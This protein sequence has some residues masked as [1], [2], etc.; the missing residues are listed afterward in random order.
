MA[1]PVSPICTAFIA[2]QTSRT[3]ERGR[4]AWLACMVLTSIAGCGGGETKPGG[5]TLSAQIEAAKANPNPQARA[6][7][8]VLL[9]DKQFQAQDTGGARETFRLA[10]QAIGQIKEPSGKAMELAVLAQGYARANDPSAAKNMAQEGKQVA[11]GISE[12]FLKVAAYASLAK[13][14]GVAKSPADAVDLLRDAENV[15]AGFNASNALEQQQQVES[16][17]SIA[18]VYHAVDRPANA[19]ALF[20]RIDQLCENID[21]DRAR[22]D[23][24]STLAAA[25]AKLG[26]P[27]AAA[28]F[29]KAV[30]AVHAIDEPN[31]KAHALAE[32]AMKM[33]DRGQ[34]N[35][36]LDEADKVALEVP[37]AGLRSEVQDKIRKARR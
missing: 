28:T 15:A 35:N 1:R 17:V 34:A 14:M 32:I 11:A 6:R 23:A 4:W 20:E 36:L 29:Q 5:Q 9:G 16:L 3:L 12:P 30:A 18:E 2:R 31:S 8:L 21:S 22:A 7:A 24:L 25:Q 37:D 10:Y 19:T 26:L 13:A 27:E 33:P